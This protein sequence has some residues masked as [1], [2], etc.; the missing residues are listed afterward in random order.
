MTVG[1]LSVDSA[2]QE[3]EREKFAA[4][5]SKA[6]SDKNVMMSRLVHAVYV[7][8]AESLSE[9]MVESP[10]GSLVPFTPLLPGLYKITTHRQAVN[11]YTDTHDS[12]FHSHSALGWSVVTTY[13]RL[14]ACPVA[15][16]C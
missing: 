2:Y 15:Q 7:G 9:A 1:G 8:V 12:A 5:E 3:K 10:V 13:Y 6:R 16:Q 4:L 14:A 11:L